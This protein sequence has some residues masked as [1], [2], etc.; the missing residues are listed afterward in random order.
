MRGMIPWIGFRQEPVVYERSKRFAGVTKYPFSKMLK[1]AL[2][3]ITSFSNAPLQTA[4]LAGLATASVCLVY[5]VYIVIHEM[6]T[7]F[8]VQGWSSLMVAILFLGAVQLITIGI[9]GEYIGR[10]YD[11]VKKRPL[12][13]VDESASRQI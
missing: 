9:L 8:P 11:E 6:V 1:L 3:G 10:I 13:I 5:A 4:F 2:D 12:F 7:G